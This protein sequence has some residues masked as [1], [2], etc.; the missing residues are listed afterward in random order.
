MLLPFVLLIG[1]SA[2]APS[3]ARPVTAPEA[4]SARLL[5]ESPR[6]VVDRRFLTLA[7]FH[8]TA[9]I[10]DVE[11]TVGMRQH[12]WYCTEEWSSWIV[13]QRPGRARLYAT[14]ALGNLA[15]GTLAYYLKR[16]GKNYWWLP[17]LSA[18]SLQ[19]YTATHNRFLSGCY[20]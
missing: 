1:F 5:A 8:A 2:P 17:Q 7:V 3:P 14:A 9:S 11:S 4:P 20:R 15:T 6:R 13:G 16:K 19:V 12:N 10:L 18:G